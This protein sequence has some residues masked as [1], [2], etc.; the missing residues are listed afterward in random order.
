MKSQLVKFIIVMLSM[1]FTF[2]V[3]SQD[4]FHLTDKERALKVEP[5]EYQQLIKHYN[6]LV[7]DYNRRKNKVYEKYDPNIEI[8]KNKIDSI[9]PIL[10]R[11]SGIRE[12]RRGE[13]YIL[14]C[15]EKKP[16]R[17]LLW[18]DT[19]IDLEGGYGGYKDYSCFI[20]DRNSKIQEYKTGNESTIESCIYHF[21]K[22]SQIMVPN[23]KKVIK[24]ILE[25]E[26]QLPNQ[27]GIHFEFIFTKGMSGLN[28]YL[29]AFKNSKPYALAK[30]YTS[31]N[32]KHFR[33]NDAFTYTTTDLKKWGGEKYIKLYDE[34]YVE[35]LTGIKNANYNR[36]LHESLEEQID[37]LNKKLK[38]YMEEK[39]KELIPIENF[40]KDTIS[41]VK[42]H[43]NDYRIHSSYL[44]AAAKHLDSITKGVDYKFEER[45]IE[46]VES[47][48]NT[49]T[50]SVRTDSS[51]LIYRE[52]SKSLNQ[53]SSQIH[54]HL[55]GNDGFNCFIEKDKDYLL[56][57]TKNL[58]ATKDE[59]DFDYLHSVEDYEINFKDLSNKIDDL[60]RHL[61]STIYFQDENCSCWHKEY[62]NMMSCPFKDVIAVYDYFDNDDFSKIN[63]SSNNSVVS[64]YNKCENY[65]HKEKLKPIINKINAE[66]QEK[67][68]ITRDQFYSWL[69]EGK[70]I[71]YG[72]NYIS[73][74]EHDKGTNGGSCLVKVGNDGYESSWELTSGMTFR[75]VGRNMRNRYDQITL[76]FSVRRDLG[77]GIEISGGTGGIYGTWTKNP[78]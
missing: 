40:K 71:E 66:I 34:D 21:L 72:Y 64:H 39:S 56:E 57:V 5:L 16:E 62:T 28:T 58:C 15:G 30:T 51:K 31:F 49:V 60:E 46:G 38:K 27:N 59:I 2:D 12:N 74:V 63:M 1:M 22:S 61:K 19:K 65:V 75:I 35:E 42:L 41:P 7:D 36:K 44:M 11:E 48:G 68:K 9:T 6:N 17:R 26:E 25:L 73:H 18:E 23:S 53:L 3:Y 78:F 52:V 8:V 67:N 77:G 32:V 45:E 69:T 33:R 4:D 43:I 54:N 47:F 20:E 50:L 10:N 76:E 29:I 13:E 70:K 37:D 14:W 24:K 55:K